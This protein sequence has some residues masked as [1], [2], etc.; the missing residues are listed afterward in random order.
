MRTYTFSNFYKFI[1]IPLIMFF[2]TWGS[3]PPYESHRLPFDGYLIP[4]ISLFLWYRIFTSP[5]KIVVRDDSVFK[6]YTILKKIELNPKDILWMR[7]HLSS[8]KIKHPTGTIVIS[9][10]MDG[11]SGLKSN[12]RSVRPDLKL[13][14]V[15]KNMFNWF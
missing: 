8:V 13:E 1:I 12:L 6:F 3:L 2:F 10:L 15:T 11:I 14:D 9:T 5:Y 4:L 7:E